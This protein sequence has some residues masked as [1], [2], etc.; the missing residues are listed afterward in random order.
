MRL[1][2]GRAALLLAVLAVLSITV[3]TLSTGLSSPLFGLSV[4]LPHSSPPPPPPAPASGILLVRVSL[5]GTGNGTLPVA[6]AAVS[7]GSGVVGAASELLT[8]NALGEA[9]IKLPP[10][11]YSLGVT[12]QS[13][14]RSMM[15]QLCRT[16]PR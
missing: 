6:G 16:A 10:G 4:S 15:F 3:G 1:A 7:V 9:E 8:T 14:A 11:N 5:S 2:R 13:S 12:T